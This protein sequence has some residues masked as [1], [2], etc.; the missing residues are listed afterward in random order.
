MTLARSLDQFYTNPVLAKR[1]CEGMLK[2]WKNADV[3]FV[4]PSAGNGAFV[5]PIVKANQDFIAFDIEPKSRLVERMNFL[6]SGIF[7]KGRYKAIVVIGNPPFGKNSSIAIKFFNKAAEFADEIAFILPRTF[8]KYSVQAKLH[9]NFHLVRDEEVEEKAFFYEGKE[10]DVPCCWQ[11]WRRKTKVRVLQPVPVVN[12]LIEFTTPDKADFAMRR[13]GFYAGR[14]KT[15]NIE[16]LSE[17]T[18]YFLKEKTKG[19]IEALNRVDW[20]SITSQ[21][22][23]TRSLSKKEL[24]TKLSDVYGV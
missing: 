24:A 4:E 10:Y 5:T 14:I 16:A 20:V 19:V 15:S 11:I 23:G 13:V 1:Y 6:E 12:Q 17:T 8:R 21:T 18:H 7:S 22:A 2:R 9:P 3:L